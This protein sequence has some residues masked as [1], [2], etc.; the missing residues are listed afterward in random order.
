MIFVVLSIFL[1][2]GVSGR[3]LRAEADSWKDRSA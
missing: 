3:V 2:G 1:V